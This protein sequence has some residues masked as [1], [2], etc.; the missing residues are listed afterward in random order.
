MSGLLAPQE[1]L[2][3]LCYALHLSIRLYG[4]LYDL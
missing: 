1:S 3:P 2:N 4:L